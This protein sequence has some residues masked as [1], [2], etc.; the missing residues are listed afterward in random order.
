MTSARHNL[1]QLPNGHWVRKHDSRHIG[2]V[3]IEE[4]ARRLEAY[5]GRAAEL[6]CPTLVVR[7]A[8]SDVL[9]HDAAA[10]FAASLANGQ[11]CASDFDCR[12]GYC[13]PFRRYCAARPSHP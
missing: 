12:S 3:D 7:G 10:H 1:R 6:T 5:W 9:A 4:L 8:E 11:A 13:D 2:S